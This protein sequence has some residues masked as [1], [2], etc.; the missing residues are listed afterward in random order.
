MKNGVS[1]NE[2][3]KEISVEDFMKNPGN[4]GYELSPDGN[5]ITYVSTWEN[6]LNVFVKNE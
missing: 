2:G 4:M 6:R 5:Y 3:V 1:N